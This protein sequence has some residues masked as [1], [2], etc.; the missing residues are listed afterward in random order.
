MTSPSNNQGL[1]STGTIALAGEC[2]DA[3]GNKLPNGSVLLRIVNGAIAMVSITQTTI[4]APPSGA[5]G[6]V[7][8]A[9][10][11]STVTVS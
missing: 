3:N 4:I 1:T 6:S 11:A 2:W 10:V 9:G 8:F 5:V 7:T